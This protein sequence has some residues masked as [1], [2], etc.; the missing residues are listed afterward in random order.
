[1]NVYIASDHAGFELKESLVKYLHD[2]KINV[3]D[4]SNSKLDILDDY[5]DFVKSVGEKVS[6]E[7]GSFGIVLGGSGQGEAVVVN[8]ISG[9]RAIVINNENL[10]LVETGRVH[11]N[12]NI[13]SLGARFISD[14]FAKK[15]VDIFLNTDFTE[16]ERHLRR[17]NKIDE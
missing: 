1:M 6:K 3:V 11:N 4:F 8:R 12:A 15:A 13:I 14:E 16:E 10:E 2:N 5:P 7:S 17:I 9:I